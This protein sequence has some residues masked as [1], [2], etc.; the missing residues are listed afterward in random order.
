[1]AANAMAAVSTAPKAVVIFMLRPHRYKVPFEH[2]I[3]S[4]FCAL[5]L[6]KSPIVAVVLRFRHRRY[7]P[8][9]IA[10][11]RRSARQGAHW[12]GDGDPLHVMETIMMHYYTQALSKK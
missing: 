11:G 8:I 7:L 3:A 4:P 6:S 10:R 12:G 1:M 9:A 5:P 2:A